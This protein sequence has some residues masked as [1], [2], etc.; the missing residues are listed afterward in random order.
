MVAP[1]DGPVTQ[2]CRKHTTI[3]DPTDC[4]GVGKAM[5]FALAVALDRWPKAWVCPP[6]PAEAP[7][8]P[9]PT[10]PPLEPPAEPPP[11]PPPPPPKRT[12]RIDA[13]VD[14]IFA[15]KIAPSISLGFSPWIGVRSVELPLPLSIE[16]GLRATWTP[17][18]AAEAAVN[19]RAAYVSGV[20]APCVRPSFFFA[21]AVLEVGSMALQQDGT[22]GYFPAVNESQVVALGLRFGGEYPFADRW[23]IRGLLEFEG[24]P[25]A[26]HLLVQHAGEPEAWTAPSLSFNIG[27]GLAFKLW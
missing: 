14:A 21:C 3:H 10:K 13:G 20:L 18:A 15:P 1:E 2:S 11:P 17:G 25:K 27:L 23:A 9:E 7:A 19:V 5:A 8:P 6:P 22:H 16:V 24:V 4:A 26:P 12:F